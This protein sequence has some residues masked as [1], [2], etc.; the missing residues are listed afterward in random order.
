MGKDIS[1]IAIIGGTGTLGGGLARCWALA[2]YPII[3]GSRTREK[4][5]SAASRLRVDTGF[6]DI[7]GT[8]NL[9]A[10]EAGEIIVVAVPWPTRN[11]LL[12]EIKNALQGKI[13]VDTTVPLVPPKI[14]RVQMPEGGSAGM[15]AQKLLGPNV[16]LVSALQN[17]AAHKLSRRKE[18]ECDVLVCGDDVEARETVIRL[19]RALGLRGLHA[20]PIDNSIAT[21]AMT[22]LLIAINGRY[23]VDGAGIRI[24]GVTPID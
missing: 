4:A 19:I 5:V 23:K 13:V 14:A 6:H 10:A 9:D 16:R 3:I 1:K 2:G 17:V 21:E 7:S 8:T 20:G 22:S 18:I 12:E 24:T 15:Q 11:V